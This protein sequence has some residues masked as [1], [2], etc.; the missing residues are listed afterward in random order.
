MQI[1]ERDAQLWARVHGALDRR[2][3]P[4]GDPDV[5]ELLLRYPDL[6]PEVERMC[7]RLDAIASVAPPRH[8]SAR[9]WF[10]AAGLLAAALVAVLAPRFRVEPTAELETAP[11]AAEIAATV[12]LAP[13]P[14]LRVLR[15]ALAVQVDGTTHAVE[16]RQLRTGG[17][18]RTETLRG[19]SSQWTA[20]SLESNETTR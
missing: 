19:P 3:D 17:L 1:D 18:L 11:V 4:F 9:P 12:P 20:E 15:F 10:V 2:E 8:S 14:T 7:A 16:G 5:Q 6:A 13:A